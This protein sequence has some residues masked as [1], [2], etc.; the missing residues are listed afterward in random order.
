MSMI[1]DIEAL[2]YLFQDV[3]PDK[4]TNQLVLDL[5]LDKSRWSEAHD[6]F[7]KIRDNNLEA[8]RKNDH[9]KESQYC[10]EEVCAQSIFNLTHT[11]M[12][13]D[14][15]SPYWVIK[16]ALQLALQL[17]VPT[18]KIVEVVVPNKSSNSDAVNSA[19]S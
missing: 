9:N 18:D 13:F 11:D 10:F 12:P 3:V 6:V 16:N 8:I 1:D 14:S 4:K 2:L 19:G 15:D 7:S 5:V 17:G